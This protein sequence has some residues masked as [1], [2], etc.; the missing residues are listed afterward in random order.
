[1]KIAIILGTRPEIIKMSP[2]IKYCKD[3]NIN[4][5]IIH[6]NQHYSPNMDK[7]FFEELDLPQPDY[8][9]NVGSGSQGEQTSKALIEIEKILLK[10]KPSIVLVQGDTNTVLAGAIATSKLKT[11]LGHIE[12]GLRS[13]DRKMPEEIN[14]VL[15]DHVSDY[16]FVPTKLQKNILLKEGI[17]K[18]KI[19][20]V[21][22]TV[23]DAVFQNLKIAN[24][25]FDVLKKIGL[26]EKNY[27]L[28]TAHRPSNVDNEKNLRKLFDIL[29]SVVDTFNRIIVYPI[30]PRTKKMIK[31][32]G[33]EFSKEIKLIEP[34]GFLE[35]L[36]LEK[37]ADL[38]LTDSGGIQEEACIL[39]VPCITLR[40]NTERPETVDV[41]ANILTGLDL[42]QIL[43]S[44]KEM[45]KRN[46]NWINPFGDGSTSNKIMK[47]ILDE[48]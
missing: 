31:K 12:A 2:I 35:F 26:K 37:K 44:I 41:G 30:H 45:L 22:N 33:I 46:N 13:Y 16:C 1:M 40:E 42:N 23:V 34:V 39:K 3:K 15:T 18:D 8:N 21:G 17:E 27:F 10:E 47:I 43:K 25:R 6:S 9:L 38:I 11:K 24:K 36:Q 48:K 7:I 29:E 4:F 32:F 14:R 28:V 20:V 19:F 5:K